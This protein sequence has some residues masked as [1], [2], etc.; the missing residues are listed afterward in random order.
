MRPLINVI[1]YGQHKGLMSRKRLIDYLSTLGFS[2][3]Q[4]QEMI[5]DNVR[6]YEL[7]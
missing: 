3:Y 6:E 4:A 5:G 1:I 2:S 7:I